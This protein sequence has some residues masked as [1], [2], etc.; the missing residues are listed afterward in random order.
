MN[1]KVYIQTHKSMLLDLI[2]VN[3]LR[4]SCTVPYLFSGILAECKIV[5]VNHEQYSMKI[6]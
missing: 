2:W 3:V 5:I 1:S 4:N 6:Y